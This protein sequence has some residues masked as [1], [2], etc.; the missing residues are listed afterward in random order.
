MVKFEFK[1]TNANN[2]AEE[3]NDANVTNEQEENCETP[4]SRSADQIC[5]DI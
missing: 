5:L 4:E 1:D 2:D 3:N